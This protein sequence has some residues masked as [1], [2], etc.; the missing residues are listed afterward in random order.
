MYNVMGEAQRLETPPFKGWEGVVLSPEQARIIIEDAYRK[1]RLPYG[2]DV[3]LPWEI[4]T[5]RCEWFFG[6]RC[7]YNI[8][9]TGRRRA[10]IDRFDPRY[11]WKEHIDHDVGTP[12]ELITV[13]LP[14]GLG[15]LIGYILDGRKGAIKGSLAGLAIGVL[16]E[17][18]T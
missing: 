17:L 16:I 4:D 1:Y 18:L 10:H 11:N 6:L 5:S 13:G 7:P 14:M 9:V 3:T 12:H 8:H 15:A 2:T